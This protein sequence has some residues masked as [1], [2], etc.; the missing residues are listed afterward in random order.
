MTRVRAVV[1]DDLPALAAIAS[2]VDESGVVSAADPRYVEHLTRL[3]RLLVAV[4]E[5]DT[6]V[7][8]GGTLE[9][10]GARFLTDLFVSPGHRGGGV[11][12]ALLR[13]LWGDATERVTSSS[14]DPRAIASY[15]RAGARPRW[16]L[17]YLHVPGV[18]APAPEVD[19]ALDPSLDWDYPPAGAVEVRTGTA[20]AA[21]SRDHDGIAV[22][23]AITPEPGELVD[24]VRSLAALAGPGARVRLAVPGPHPALPALLDLGARV[25]DVDLW[26][27]SDGAATRWDPSRELPHPGLG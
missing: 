23:R 25:R 18:A 21:V 8:Y 5:A 27:A 11:G 26:S 19:E 14:Q 3:G 6:P 22:R 16:P 13:E 12:G 24:L 7:A 17:V 9:R 15:T 4:D 2:A 10:R 20:A 1:D